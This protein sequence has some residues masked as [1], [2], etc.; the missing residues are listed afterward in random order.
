MIRDMD[1][2]IL[3]CKF[4]IDVLECFGLVPFTFH[5]LAVAVCFDGKLPASRVSSRQARSYQPFYWQCF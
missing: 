2:G 3:K 1:A 5:D 4:F